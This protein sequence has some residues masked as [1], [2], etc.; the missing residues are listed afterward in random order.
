MK[1][2]ILSLL[3]P[4][5]LFIIAIEVEGKVITLFEDDESFIDQL[6]RQD[7]PTNIEN[8]EKD[9][10]YGKIAIKVSAPQGSV[11]NNVQRYNPNIPGWNY[12]IVE[13]PSKEDE[14]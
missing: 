9:V 12:K 6:S 4:M 8:E 5:L 11:A 14:A 10:F 1:S 3:A 7:T 13:N 2:L